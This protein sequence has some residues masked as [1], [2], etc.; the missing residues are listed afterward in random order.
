[1]GLEKFL[2][3]TLCFAGLTMEDSESILRFLS[4]IL[5]DK[6]FVKEGFEEAVIKREK[7]FPTAL[8]TS[9]YKVAIPHTDSE[10]VNKSVISIASLQEPVLFNVMGEPEKTLPVSVIFLLV[11][12][13]KEKQVEVISELIEKIIKDE[14]LIEKIATSARG[15][16]IYNVMLRKLKIN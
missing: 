12:K 2:N 16:E 4:K 1:M 14:K 13:E 11:I 7:E 5:F 9:G 10:Y 3:E 6:G 15:E 8:P